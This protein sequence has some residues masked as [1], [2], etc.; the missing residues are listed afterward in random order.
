M[1]VMYWQLNDIWA[2]ASWSSIDVAGEL[3]HRLA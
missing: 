2:G 1:G 3:F